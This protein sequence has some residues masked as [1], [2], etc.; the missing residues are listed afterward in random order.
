MRR[1][2]KIFNQPETK[3]AWKEYR[4]AYLEAGYII[5]KASQKAYQKSCKKAYNSIVKM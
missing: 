2:W 5:R 1:L 4:V 3:K